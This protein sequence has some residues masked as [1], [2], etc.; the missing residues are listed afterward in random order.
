MTRDLLKIFI[1]AACLSGIISPAVR[2]DAAEANSLKAL[3]EE[4]RANNPE[5]RALEQK[6]KAVE[7][8]ATAE[9]AFDDPTLKVEL[10]DLPRD[11]PLNISPGNAMMTRY[12]LSQMFPFPGKLSL[13]EKIALKEAVMAKA[14][15]RGRELEVTNLVKDA[16]FDYAYMNESLEAIKAIKELLSIMS[17]AAGT[18]YSTGG[19]SQQDVIK[20]NAETV[21]L[22]NDIITIEARKEVGAARLKNLLGRA[23]DSALFDSAA[24][25]ALPKKRIEFKTEEILKS[26]L[27]KNPG[28]KMAE[29]EVEAGELG[30]RLAGKNYYPDFMVG[31]APV[32]RDGRF[33]TFDFMLQMNIPIWGGKYRG[34]FAEAEAN[35]HA[36]RAR[37][38][39]EKNMKLFEVKEAALMVEAAGRMMS[40]YET[41]LLPT[42]EISFES[43]LKNYQS[44]RIDLIML[45]DTQRELKKTKL[46]YL[47]A[48]VEYRKTVASLERLVGAD[49]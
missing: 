14:A 20:V 47:G 48:V 41:G 46:G 35:S 6:A 17:A 9:G 43:A 29:A 40:L 44:G 24:P 31:V 42:A 38:L 11:R 34:L 27:E 16:Y 7:A 15:F 4:A 18:R 3:I 12:T 10:E 8:R 28:I 37:L 22:E 45:L 32:E 19:V 5:L 33:D 21:M 39:A 1:L 25:D 26:A 23:Q 13:K 30:T 49:F 2:V 36:M